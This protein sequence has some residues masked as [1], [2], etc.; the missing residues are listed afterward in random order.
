MKSYEGRTHGVFVGESRE[1]IVT[2]RR[3]EVRVIFGGIEGDR[4]A[5]LTRIA[6][7][8]D[9]GRYERGTE[10][11]NERQISIV[12]QEDLDHMAE[13][14]GLSELPAELIGTNISISGI[15]DFSKLPIGTELVFSGGVVLRVEEENLPCLKAGKAIN[16][17]HGH[18]DPSHFPKISIDRRGVVA[19]VVT[20]GVIREGEFFTVT[21]S[22]EQQN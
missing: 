2:T 20:P 21:L 5:G 7:G 9:K 8:R 14:L 18:I 16:A 22:E 11:R 4:H 17:V 15:A 19:S 12:A 13:Q 1:S 3:G 10:I 6:G